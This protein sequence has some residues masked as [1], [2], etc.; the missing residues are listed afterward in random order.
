MFVQFINNL[1][2]IDLLVGQGWKAKRAKPGFF[3]EEDEEEFI[4]LE[5]KPWGDVRY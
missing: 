3:E 1:I 2:G 5:E 4:S